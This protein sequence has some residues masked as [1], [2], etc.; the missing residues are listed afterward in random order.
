MNRIL[1][2]GAVVFGLLFF[3]TLTPEVTAGAFAQDYDAA[4][5][6]YRVAKTKAEYEAAAQRFQALAER[7]DAGLYK[8]NALYWLAECWYDLKQYLRALNG[9]ERVLLFPMSNKE[10]DARFKVALC[11]ARLGWVKGARWEFEQFLRDYPHSANA[12]KARAELQRLN[13]R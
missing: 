4:M 12:S 11:Y 6:M 13:A 10:A 5:A 8:V 7:K 1:M 3:C 2:R 9:F